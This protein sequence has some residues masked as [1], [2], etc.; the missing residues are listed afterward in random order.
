MQSPARCHLRATHRRA[1]KPPASMEAR[2]SLFAKGF[3]LMMWVIAVQA[4]IKL[5]KD[6][7][8]MSAMDLQPA[9]LLRYGSILHA[10][11]STWVA[12]A[13]WLDKRRNK[14]HKSGDRADVTLERHR[15]YVGPT[16]R[17]GDMAA[18]MFS[19]LYFS[20][21][22]ETS[23]L[24]DVG[25]GSLRLGRLAIPFLQRGHY[26]CIEPSLSALSSGVRHEL[27]MDQLQMKWPTFATNSDF[28]P[29]GGTDAVDSYDYLIAQSVLAHTAE[30]LLEAALPRLRQ[31]MKP[32]SVLLATFVVHTADSTLEPLGANTPAA[33]EARGWLYP[34]CTSFERARLTQLVTRVGLSNVELDWPH[35]SQRWFALCL[36]GISASSPVSKATR[37]CEHHTC[38][39]SF[40]L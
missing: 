21:L 13:A 27:G 1:I 19:L 8:A 40:D 3:V 5:V 31:K 16:G 36:V 14:R 34:E 39:N 26:H 30:D 33:H 28:T 7:H 17:Y 20:G 11:N 32:H 6:P 25:C 2:G 12:H 15:S 18:S 9:V 23:L 37:L 29:P 22:R 10:S 38:C 4:V 35:V 24:L